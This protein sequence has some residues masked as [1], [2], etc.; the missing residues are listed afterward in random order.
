[1]RQISRDPTVRYRILGL[2]TVNG[3]DGGYF[4]LEGFTSTGLG[5]SRGP[6]GELE[7]LASQER[8]LCVTNGVFDPS[9]LIDGR[10]R[11]VASIVQRQGQPKFR[12]DLLDA[13]G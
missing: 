12:A 3:W 10:Q 4:F 11:I 5:R 7:L 8:L 13:Y 1:M 9:S 2:A 6:A